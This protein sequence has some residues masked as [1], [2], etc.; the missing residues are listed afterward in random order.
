M[1]QCQKVGYPYIVPML[2]KKKSKDFSKNQNKLL[3]E[4]YQKRK[5]K[6]QIS[7][8]QWSEQNLPQ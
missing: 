7:T 5:R 2:L 4:S 8:I 3:V 6:A 1:A